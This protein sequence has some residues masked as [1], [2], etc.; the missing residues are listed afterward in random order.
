MP[1]GGTPNSQSCISNAIPWALVV[2]ALSLPWA[3]AFPPL[4]LHTKVL[5]ELCQSIA[6]LLLVSL[7][8]PTQPWFPDLLELSIDH[9]KQLPVRKPWSGRFCLD[10]GRLQLYIWRLSGLLVRPVSP[11]RQQ[12]GLQLLR[13]CPLSPTITESG[14]SFFPGVVDERQILLL[15]LF[16]R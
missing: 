11:R 16:P 10:P 13:L 12:I 9:P 7:A 14:E 2:D 1:P 5:T 3:F 8:W 6:Q 15:P 4:Q